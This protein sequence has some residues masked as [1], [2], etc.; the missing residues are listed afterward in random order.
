[1]KVKE[2]KLRGRHRDTHAALQWLRQNRNRF[3]GNVYEPMLLEVSRSHLQTPVLFK[4]R[5]SWRYWSFVDAT[6]GRRAR[7][8]FNLC[9]LDQCERSPLCQICGEP[10]FIPGPASLCFPEER[11]HGDFHVWGQWVAADGCQFR[12][13]LRAQYQQNTEIPEPFTQSLSLFC[14]PLPNF[15]IC[16]QVR[17]K[18]NL[19]VNSISAPEQSRSK[20]RPSQNIEDLRWEEEIHKNEHQSFYT[21]AWSRLGVW[22]LSFCYHSVP[23]YLCRRFGFFTYLREMFDAPDEVMSYLCQQYNVHNVP[24]GTEQTK[25]MIRQVCL[26]LLSIR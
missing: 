18:M 12:S 14:L 13:I 1:M 19:K 22:A 20:E 17:D 26:F 15:T 16:P 3:K 4:I 10:H 11:G 21:S 7:K 23:C 2:E 25:T 6:V 5:G 9:V 8:F 24:V